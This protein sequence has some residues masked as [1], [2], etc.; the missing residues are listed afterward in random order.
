MFWSG[1]GSIRG[2]HHPDV[3]WPNGGWDVVRRDVRP[4]DWR[5]GATTPVTFRTFAREHRRQL[6][7]YW[8]QEGKRVWTDREEDEAHLEG[9]PGHRWIRERLLGEPLEESGRLSVLIGS[10][11][12]DS[13]ELSEQLLVAFCRDLMRELYRA[14][15]WA[16]P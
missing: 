9:T 15:P 13:G 16:A 6:I 2:Y 8:T 1:S 4:I 7:C 10:E 14:V 3:C 12:W 11:M 5:V